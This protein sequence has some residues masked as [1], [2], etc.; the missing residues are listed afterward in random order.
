MTRVISFAL[1]TF[2]NERNFVEE[3][4]IPLHHLG[5]IRHSPPFS[6]VPW[7]NRKDSAVPPLSGVEKERPFYMKAK[8]PIGLVCFP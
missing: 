8:T 7:E 1:A 6:H 2:F 5:L 3:W 4:M